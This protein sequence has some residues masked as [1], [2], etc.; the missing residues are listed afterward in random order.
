M[1]SDRWIQS[2][3]FYP[4]SQSA[5][6]STMPLSSL[7]TCTSTAIDLHFA[8]SLVGLYNISTEFGCCFRF[9]YGIGEFCERGKTSFVFLCFQIVSTFCRLIQEDFQLKWGYVSG[10]GDLNGKKVKS[11]PIFPE[12]QRYEGVSKSFRT[13]SITKYTLTFGITRWEDTQTVMAAKFTILT[14]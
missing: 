14:H 11:M 5:S 7:V 8:D 3:C 2:T 12:R 6:T 9:R 4:V 1:S 13:E 10:T